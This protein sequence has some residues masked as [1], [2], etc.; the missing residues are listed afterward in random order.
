MESPYPVGASLLSCHLG[1]QL[2]RQAHKPGVA[3]VQIHYNQNKTSH[4][5]L[6]ITGSGG[7]RMMSGPEFTHKCVWNPAS[8][9]Q[10]FTISFRLF[11]R[12]ES[13]YVQNVLHLYDGTDVK[14]VI[15]VVNLKVHVIEF[16]FTKNVNASNKIQE[17]ESNVPIKEW[18]DF[19]MVYDTS[20][21]GSDKKVNQL[22]FYLN[23][24]HQF[25]TYVYYNAVHFFTTFNEPVLIIGCSLEDC[26]NNF[27]IDDITI[28]HGVYKIGPD[29]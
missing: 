12:E 25:I 27:I 11:L 20:S 18:V 24:R 10:G 16:I 17:L 28:W 8:C 2:F 19:V 1:A 6:S 23:G 3:I 26:M 15:L 7:V 14:V 21:I 13:T 29:N 9:E 4:H 5:A 22:E